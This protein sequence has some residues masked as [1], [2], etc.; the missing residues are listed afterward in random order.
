MTRPFLSVMCTEEQKAKWL[1]LFD[2]GLIFGAYA[3]TE[4]GHGSD[5]QSLETEAVYDQTRKEFILNSPT[6]SSLKWWPGELANIST[7][8]VVF[9]KTVVGGKK[10]GVL[11]FIV[12]IRDFATH[13]PM[14]GIE[15]GDIGP[16]L[17]YH[18]K[19]NGFLKLTNVRVPLENM[20]ARFSEVTPEGALVSK[21]NPK[22]IYSAMMRT[23]TL[24]IEFSS[25]FLGMGVAIALRYS[26]L[27][28]QFKNEQ[29]EE[30]PVIQYQLQQL[31]LFGT[32]GSRAG[33]APPAPTEPRA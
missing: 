28:R 31:K 27:R 20:P 22:I 21:G 30:V 18:A 19:E 25:S 32:A 8:A 3:Q 7:V 11:P 6:V 29:R 4:M 9:A 26:F 16:K 12:Q 15:L 17:S 33:R 5:V 23:R 2:R 10:V 24:L 1:P 14:P 13:R